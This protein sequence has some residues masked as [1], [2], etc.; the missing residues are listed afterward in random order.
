MT[1][2]ALLQTSALALL[3]SEEAISLEWG[4]DLWPEH[5]SDNWQMTAEEP[6]QGG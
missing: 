1:G 4:P 6:W 2:S 5:T 3:E